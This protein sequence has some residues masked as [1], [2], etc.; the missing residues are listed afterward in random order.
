MKIKIILKVPKCEN[1]HRMVNFEDVIKNR[2]RY[3]SQNAHR[4]RWKKK[5]FCR[6]MGISSLLYDRTMCVPWRLNWRNFRKAGRFL[7]GP[8]KS[9]PGKK[10]QAKHDPGIKVS[11]NTAALAQTV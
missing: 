9:L 10:S 6:V 5:T 11:S 4:V 1:F 2:A 3:D 7:P 8:A